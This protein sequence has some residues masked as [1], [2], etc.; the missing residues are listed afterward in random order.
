M[1]QCLQPSGCLPHKELIESRP[2]IVWA[3]HIAR[4]IKGTV[5]APPAHPMSSVEHTKMGKIVMG[6]GGHAGIC[7]KTSEN[8]DFKFRMKG[9]GVAQW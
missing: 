6:N 2:Q 7:W 4:D 5:L 8:V 1:N 9:W 3:F